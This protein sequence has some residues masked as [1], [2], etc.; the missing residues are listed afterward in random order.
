MHNLVLTS[1]Y[2]YFSVT[3][4]LDIVRKYQHP[5]KMFILL[6]HPKSKDYILSL[7]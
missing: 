1:E 4:N 2:A 3:F 7:T 5:S 6:A